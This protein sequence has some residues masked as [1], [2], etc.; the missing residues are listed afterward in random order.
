MESKT[1]YYDHLAIPNSDEITEFQRKVYGVTRLIPSG[2]M[3]TYGTIAKLIKCKSS[4]AV[5]QALKRNPWPIDLEDVDS[6]LMV[7]C[8]RVIA[9]NGN[10]GGFSGKRN[11]TQIDRKIKLLRKEGIRFTLDTQNRKYTLQNSMQH[12]IV[13][14]F[15]KIVVKLKK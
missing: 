8:H 2:Y 4:Q 5:G 11:G 9:Q 13:R 7:P 14:K 6:N 12:K 10:I 1:I 3:T 15:R